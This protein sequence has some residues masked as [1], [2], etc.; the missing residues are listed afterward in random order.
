M[1]TSVAS[2]LP[3]AT[4]TRAWWPPVATGAASIYALALIAPVGEICS[5]VYPSVCAPETRESVAV[6]SVLILLVVVA[7]GLIL[8]ALVGSAR[9]R[10]VSRWVTAGIVVAGVILFGRTLLFTGFGLSPIP[11]I[12]A[13][14]TT[15]LILT[16][17]SAVIAVIGWVL[18]SH[19]QSVSPTVSHSILRVG[20]V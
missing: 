12:D 11:R 13:S 8:L 5:A 10:T 16:A 2:S 9:R 17:V 6:Q 1:D 20:Q 19:V 7:A 4:R 15:P 18:D 3:R 14:L